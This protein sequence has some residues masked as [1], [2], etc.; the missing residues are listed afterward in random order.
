[1]LSA[2]S[3][4]KVETDS[5]PPADVEMLSA[6]KLEAV[7]PKRTVEQDGPEVKVKGERE[8]GDKGV[9]TKE[10]LKAAILNAALRK[11]KGGNLGWF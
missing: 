1:M 3:Q 2:K 11:Q 5:K 8:E 6:N 4:M 7:G 9:N 10:V